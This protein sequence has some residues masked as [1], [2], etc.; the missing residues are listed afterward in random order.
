MSY[1]YV[2]G[3]GDTGRVKVGYSNS[4]PERRVQ[5][6]K[7]GARAF[8]ECDEFD[9]WISIDHKEGIENEKSLIAWCR[10]KTGIDV[11]EYFTIPYAEVMEYAKSLKMTPNHPAEEPAH[12]HGLDFRVELGMGYAAH[13]ALK[14]SLGEDT[15]YAL[16]FVLNP[17]YGLPK[18]EVARDDL[19]PEIFL[20]VRE[21]LGSMGLGATYL[22]M[23]A[24]LAMLRIRANLLDRKRQ[25]F[26]SGRADLLQSGG[27]YP[28]LAVAK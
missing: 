15:V 25:A 27:N 18:G 26:E 7:R 14:E 17:N 22:D 24:G 3:F 10:E 13:K 2:V 16:E 6:H 12:D 9:E 23:V 4:N 8:L 19:D 20:E 21:I 1:I 5:A 28:H 11:G